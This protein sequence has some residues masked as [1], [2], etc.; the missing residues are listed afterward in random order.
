MASTHASP[1]F[2]L[3]SVLHTGDV[4]RAA[5]F[6]ESLLGWTALPVESGEG[7]FRFLQGHGDTV[8]AIHRSPALN[9]WV[10]HVSVDDCEATTAAA[11]A[12]GAAPVTADAVAGVAEL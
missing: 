8:A 10:P 6:Y 4:D 3:H 2:R 11:V 12:L 7:R 9:K 5:T 1:R